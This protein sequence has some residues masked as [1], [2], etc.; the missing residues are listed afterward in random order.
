MI[1]ATRAPAGSSVIAALRAQTSSA[2]DI[3]PIDPVAPP[4]PPPV[5]DTLSIIVPAYHA[6]ATLARTLRSLTAVPDDRRHRLE[7]LVVDDGSTDATAEVAQRELAALAPAATRLI[8]KPNG[9]SATAR[10]AGLDAASADWLMF[11]DADD[12]LIADPTR[13]I[14]RADH[15]R[16]LTVGGQA[17]RDGKVI[18]R[19]PPVRFPP[20]HAARRLTAANPFWNCSVVFR[21]DLIRHPFPTAI[22]SGED[23]CFWLANAHLFEAFTPC[24]DPPVV[25]I[26][27]HGQNKSRL[28]HQ[29]GVGRQWIAEQM[30]TRPPYTDRPVARHNLLLQRQIGILQQGGRLDLRRHLRWPVSPALFAKFIAYATL[31][32]RFGWLDPYARS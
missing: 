32:S 16:C 15:A 21:R 4:E 2:Q 1:T 17:V 27:L 28:Q 20:R 30:L 31:R 6:Q 11:L 5:P 18:Q 22:R 19:R 29:R 7:V 3:L 24:P 26:H 25:R 10:N 12:E 14:D 13:L 23:W 8:R 9:G